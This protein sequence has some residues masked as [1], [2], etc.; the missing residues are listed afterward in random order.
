MAYQTRDVVDAIARQTGLE[1]FELKAD[2]GASRNRWLM[3]FQADLLGIPVV[4]SPYSDAT[5]IGSAIAA[6]LTS[7]LW[8]SYDDLYAS[9]PESARFEP[10]MSKDERET[11]YQKWGMAVER[12]KGWAH[13]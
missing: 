4:V 1:I 8:S 7:G 6:G 3:Q 13:P 11:L 9:Q 12:S 10:S 2:G 5:S